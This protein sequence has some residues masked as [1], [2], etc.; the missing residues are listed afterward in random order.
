MTGNAI[1]ALTLGIA[2]AASFAAAAAVARA[3]SGAAR[4]T[5]APAEAA[6]TF[7]PCQIEDLAGITVYTAECT[8]FDVPENPAKPNERHIKLRVARV[9]A[10]NRRKEPDPLFLL[11]GGPGMSATTLY[12]NAAP[13]FAAS[14]AIGTS[15]SSTSAAPAT[16]TR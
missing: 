2:L 4:A 10:I 13:A 11:A 7:A 12:G 1:R 8:D 16:R 9:P 5:A 3:N 6:L 15:C 14:I